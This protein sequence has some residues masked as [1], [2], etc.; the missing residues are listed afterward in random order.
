MGIT[1]RGLSV[2]AA[3]LAGSY[4]GNHF[5]AVGISGTAFNVSQ[6]TL[7]SEFDR[8]QIDTNDLS[9][10]SQV[11]LI[12]NWSPLDISGCVLREFGVFT[13]SNNMLSRNL[14]T[15]SLVFDGEQELQIQDTI[16]FYL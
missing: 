9:T 13:S 4:V 11:T 16:K 14:I 10:V 7:G 5:M 1:T 15:G 3:A 6:T 2:C 8:N 12:C